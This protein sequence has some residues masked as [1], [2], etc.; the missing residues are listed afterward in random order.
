MRLSILLSF[1]LAM[2]GSAYPAIGQTSPTFAET[3][4]ATERVAEAYFSAYIARDWDVLGEHLADAGSFAD[5]TAE[6]VFG[7]VAVSGRLATLIY[8][9]ENYASIKSMQFN[10]SRAIFSGTHAVFEGTL[11]W[12]MVLQSGKEVVTRDMPFVTILRLEGDKVV[13]HRD[14]ADYHPFIVAHRLA[15]AEK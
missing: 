15:T 4:V 13:E 3:S 8:F 9:R 6:P 5:P 7:K 14:Y 1:A 12:T 11:N 2:L 10:R